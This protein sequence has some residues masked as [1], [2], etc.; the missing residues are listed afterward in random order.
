MATTSTSTSQTATAYRQSPRQ[1]T[2]E[3]CKAA[4]AAAPPQA[5]LVLVTRACQRQIL[6]PTS[7]LAESSAD[8]RSVL[9]VTA[10]STLRFRLC[11]CLL[12]ASDAIVFSSGW[13]KV[14]FCEALLGRSCYCQVL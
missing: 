3:N 6:A 8:Q 5:C 12:H 9:L 2:T 13:C 1:G 7:T 4:A 14:P 10:V 11:G